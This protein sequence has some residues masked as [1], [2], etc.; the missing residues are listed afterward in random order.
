M[1][2]ETRHLLSHV[3]ATNQYNN[4]IRLLSWASLLALYL[5]LFSS[6]IQK[7]LKTKNCNF[8]SAENKHPVKCLCKR[9]WKSLSYL[10]FCGTPLFGHNIEQTI[11]NKQYGSVMQKNKLM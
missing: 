3:S 8:W 7:L 10:D 9:L 5:N 11:A 2:A 6:W 1:P 4:V